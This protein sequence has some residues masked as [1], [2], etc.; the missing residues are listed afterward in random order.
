MI[1]EIGKYYVLFCSGPYDY[2]VYFGVGIYEGNSKTYADEETA[3]EFSKN[4][5]VVKELELL[6]SDIK[7]EIT[8][9]QYEK[10]IN[11]NSHRQRKD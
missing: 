9:E 1:P 6:G 4:F 11:E 2:N 3:Y 8:K 5:P 7:L 10:F